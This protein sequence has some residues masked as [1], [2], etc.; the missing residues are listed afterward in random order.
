MTNHEVIW[1]CIRHKLLFQLHSQQL[2]VPKPSQGTVDLGKGEQTMADMTSR[3]EIGITGILGWTTVYCYQATRHVPSYHNHV[4]SLT[5]SKHSGKKKTKDKNTDVGERKT[6]KEGLQQTE[7]IPCHIFVCEKSRQ[8]YKNVD[9][10]NKMILV[11]S[12]SNIFFHLASM[13]TEVNRV[14]PSEAQVLSFIYCILWS[15]W[16]FIN[17]ETGK[18]AC[19]GGVK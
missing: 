13:Y 17:F 2:K 18:C 8:I 7:C 19:I 3:A 11:S 10:I 14:W 9:G 16:R 5:E 1:Q 15:R 4:F 12:N 6:K